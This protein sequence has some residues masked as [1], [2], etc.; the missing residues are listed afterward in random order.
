MSLNL[1]ISTLIP[2]AGAL[3]DV[4]AFA[5]TEFSAGKHATCQLGELRVGVKTQNANLRSASALNETILTS[6]FNSLLDSS[7]SPDVESGSVDIDK[8]Y[9]IFAKLCL[10][11]HQDPAKVTT[12]LLLTHG[13]SLNSLYWDLPGSSF[14]DAAA[15][16]GYATLAY[17]RLGA[18][19]SEHPDPIQDVQ[20]AVQVEIVHQLTQALRDGNIDGKHKFK[21]VIGTAHSSGNILLI[22]QLLKYPK[23]TDAA[24]LTGFTINANAMSA[25]LAANAAADVPAAQ[26]PDERFHSLAKGY[27]VQSTAQVV[28]FLYFYFPYYSQQGQS[29]LQFN[30]A[31]HD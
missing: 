2:C 7:S 22:G 14:V 25:T 15:D 4:S 12:V 20:A 6:T 17:D 11:S 31:F 10:P 13:G 29:S 27:Y 21:S 28:Q 30:I 3:A 19:R 5:S 18:G 8:T 9:R 26:I 23:D 1:F 24:I 16:A